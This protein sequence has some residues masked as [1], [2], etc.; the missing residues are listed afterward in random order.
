M[1]FARFYGP[2]ADQPATTATS[3]PPS[4]ADNTTVAR[5][6]DPELVVDLESMTPGYEKV[7]LDTAGSLIDRLGPDDSAGLILIPGKGIELTRDH[8]PV[9][10]ALADARGFAISCGSMPFGSIIVCKPSQPCRIWILR[11]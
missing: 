11:D 6:R 10:Q 4:F 2:E 1:S 5:G 9:R 3:A 8:A 7:V